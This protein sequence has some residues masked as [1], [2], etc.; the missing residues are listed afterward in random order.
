MLGIINE[1]NLQLSEKLLILSKRSSRE[2]LL[3]FL[4]SEA[5]KAG[6]NQF[7]IPFSRQE[8]ADYLSLDRSALSNEISKMQKDGLIL[9]NRKDFTLLTEELPQ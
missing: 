9:C 1:K 2:K 7:H 4:S 6:S 3:A 8:L 5:Q